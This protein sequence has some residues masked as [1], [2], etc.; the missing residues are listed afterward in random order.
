MQIHGLSFSADSTEPGL[1]SDS[2]MPLDDARAFVSR[3]E[4]EGY[5]ASYAPDT[6][7]PS[8]AWIWVT[9]P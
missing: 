8:L 4:A 7:D 3:L 2:S 1:V 5:E 6:N 9:A